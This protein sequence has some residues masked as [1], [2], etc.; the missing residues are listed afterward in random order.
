[1]G[2][3]P[4]FGRKKPAAIRPETACLPPFPPPK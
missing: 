2:K 1:M 3:T 4:V